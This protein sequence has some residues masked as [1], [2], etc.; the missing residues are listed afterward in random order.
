MPSS[1]RY[2]LNIVKAVLKEFEIRAKC[3]RC[4]AMSTVPARW[5][6]FDRGRWSMPQFI[7]PR[8]KDCDS[9]HMNPGGKAGWMVDPNEALSEYDQKW[10]PIKGLK[11]RK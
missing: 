11:M 10:P 4:G 2:D 1:D 5:V 6:R 9:C 8:A 7:I 3:V